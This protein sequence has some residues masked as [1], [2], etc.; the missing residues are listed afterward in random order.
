VSRAIKQQQAAAGCCSISSREREE[1]TPASAGQMSSRWGAGSGSAHQAQLSR[2][3]SASN[4]WLLQQQQLQRDCTQ[5][6]AQDRSEQREQISR[7]NSV[8]AGAAAVAGNRQLCQLPCLH[9]AASADRPPGFWKVCVEG[10]RPRCWQ[11][12][13]A[14]GDSAVS[15]AAAACNGS[16]PLVVS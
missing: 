12:D 13:M 9:G 8:Q 6:R 14:A 1:H 11:Q 7:V 5:V 15:A 16:Q 2:A 3:S 4:W 10:C